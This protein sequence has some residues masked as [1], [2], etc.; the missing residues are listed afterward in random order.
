MCCRSQEATLRLPT[1][2]WASC[3]CSWREVP[4]V[5][6]F[7]SVIKPELNW[8]SRLG[9]SC[10]PSVGI[11]GTS[12]PFAGPVTAASPALPRV[13][14]RVAVMAQQ[15]QQVAVTTQLDDQT[16]VHNY[17]TGVTAVGEG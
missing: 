14:R 8:A 5:T 13:R 9:A 2:P 17:M 15:A 16:N 1:C 4:D 12:V 6:N 7:N 10:L 11:Q 3:R